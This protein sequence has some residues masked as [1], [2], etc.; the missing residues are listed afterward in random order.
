MDKIKCLLFWGGG[1]ER[2]AD[3]DCVEVISTKKK[4]LIYKHSKTIICLLTL[5]F[6]FVHILA[7]LHN[8]CQAHP[9][10]QVYIIS[11]GE[12]EYHLSPRAV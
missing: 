5:I 6:N 11:V 2:V 8:V 10:T 9:N 3:C 1:R 12:K 4:K 7:N